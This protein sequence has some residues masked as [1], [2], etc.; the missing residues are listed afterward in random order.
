MGT[1]VDTSKTNYVTDYT[2]IVGL[3]VIINMPVFQM[4]TN[5]PANH[6]P[7]SFH[8]DMTN[9]IHNMLNKPKQ[10]VVIHTIPDQ[11]FTSGNST[12]PSIMCELCSVGGV[13]AEQNRG[14]TEVLI[15]KL[16]ECLKVPVDRIFVS[17]SLM[18]GDFVGWN[19]KTFSKSNNSLKM[20]TS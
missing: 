4:Y 8:H 12:V 17:F 5:L 7:E 9:F 10:F 16:H 13:S 11:L 1:I 3:F 15:N 14:Y 20:L 18:D 6:I 2:I 19:S